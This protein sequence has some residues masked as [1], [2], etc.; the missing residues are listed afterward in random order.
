M[1]WTK[2]LFFTFLIGILV[3][4][5][6]FYRWIFANL[7]YAMV[8]SYILDPFVSWFERRRIPRWLSV[9]SVY[10]VLIGIVAWFTA[11]FIP[12]LVKQG[13]YLF[14]IFKS[15]QQLSGKYIVN[16]PFVNGIYEF[17]QDMDTKL[18]G[19]LLA[20]KM[21]EILDNANSALASIP[22]LLMD[23]Y[24]NILSTLSLIATIPLLS[25]FMLKDKYKLRKAAMEL[26]S[27]RYFELCIILL[28]KFDST[29]GTF[30]R[31]MLFE[32]IAVGFMASIA[33]GIVGVPN[34]V[35]IGA[36]AGVANIIPYFGPFMGGALAALTLLINGSPLIMVVYAALAM[37]I[38]QIID[39]NIVYPLVVGTTISMHPL[40]VLLTVIA[41]G[42]YGGILWMLISV[43]LVYI[44]YSLIKVLYTNLKDFRII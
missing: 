25:F 34:P 30:L 15:G 33:F 29:V 43:P 16:L 19:L 12:D 20:P 42:W 18:P 37:Y 13:N 1:N 7:V 8:F 22:K 41:G 5:V 21:V 6:F 38:V 2:T 32:V 3:L 24:Q 36:T 35:L 11:H 27:N 28:R 31:A 4:G 14:D 26:A 17:M 39:N 10:L 40:L 9:V 23:N 44:S